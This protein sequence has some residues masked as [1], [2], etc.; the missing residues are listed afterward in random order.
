MGSTVLFNAKPSNTIK[1]NALTQIAYFSAV[2]LTLTVRQTSDE[3]LRQF[4]VSICKWR[5][6]GFMVFPL[7]NRTFVCDSFLCS[8]VSITNSV[9]RQ[10]NTW[11]WQDGVKV[12]HSDRLITVK[13]EMC[14]QEIL[15]CLQAS[16]AE[17]HTI[18]LL[19]ARLNLPARD[20]YVHFFIYNVHI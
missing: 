15:S 10:Q 9:Y 17:W 4:S 7:W 18:L 14:L 19:C 3:F 8:Y 6:Q 5:L 11:L 2:L 13:W 12:D 16:C 20:L 1:N